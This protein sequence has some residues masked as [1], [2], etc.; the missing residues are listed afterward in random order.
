MKKSNIISILF[1]ALLLFLGISAIAQQND[2]SGHIFS[3]TVWSDTVN[4]VGDIYIEN[5]INLIINPGTHVSFTDYYKMEV[6]GVV[7]AVGNANDT[8][9]FSVSDTNGFYNNYN[10]NG[11]WEGIKLKN[12]DQS[13]DTSVFSFCHFQYAK[14]FKIDTSGPNGSA[15]T[16]FA[17]ARVKILNCRFSQSKGHIKAGAFNAWDSSYSFIGYSE[18]HH[19]FSTREAGAIFFYKGSGEIFGNK[20][21]HNISEFRGGGI[22]SM[23]SNV[24]IYN[25]KIVNNRAFDPLHNPLVGFGGA[26]NIDGGSINV[27]NNVICNNSSFFGGAIFIDDGEHL[28][29]NNTIVN[30]LA[31]NSIAGIYCWSNVSAIIKNCIVYGNSSEENVQILGGSNTEI[32][33]CNVEG[34]ANTNFNID[35]DPRFVN[36]TL[37]AGF[38]YNALLADWN[39]SLCSANVNKGFNDPNLPDTDYNSNPRIMNS[40][41]D[42]GCIE[43]QPSTIGS[44]IS[45]HIVCHDSS[46]TEG[47]VHL[48]H[49]SSGTELELEDIVDIDSLGNY[50]FEAL[51]DGEYIVLF[52]PDEEHKDNILKTYFQ[53]DYYWEDANNILFEEG[54]PINSV[55]INILELPIL[56]G[57]MEINGLVQNVSEEPLEGVEVLLKKVPDSIYARTFTSDQG[58]FLFQYLPVGNYEIL[59]DI[60][61]LPMDS[62]YIVELGK[63]EGIEY[64]YIVDTNR[65]YIPVFETIKEDFFSN[66]VNVYPN[67]S[68]DFINLHSEDDNFRFQ[69][70]DLFNFMG[71]SIFRVNNINLNDY[72]IDMRAYSK[73]IYFLKIRINDKTHTLKIIHN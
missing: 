42:I 19:N 62:I 17:N 2:F 68:F 34:G 53:R 14:S 55:N 46:F 48:Y 28:L 7:S 63:K 10:S 27:V 40:R 39:L 3:D 72:R 29:L 36:P 16:A 50:S 21:H 37:N 38:E 8:I 5:D 49:F 35:A 65:I 60:P 9:R 69:E 64:K 54:T 44:N 70:I 56:N 13:L 25:N 23:Y 22:G 73:G 11:G 61:G 4:I 41:V 15:I 59:V 45:G 66:V 67:P 18:F 6:E 43:Y 47:Y 26:I 31:H 33:Y 24:N 51:C 58:L 32:S 52:L 20:I 12:S 1:F 30:N 71:R 57:D